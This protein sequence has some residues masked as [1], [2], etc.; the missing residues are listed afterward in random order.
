MLH[1]AV[2]VGLAAPQQSLAGMMGDGMTGRPERL[3]LQG[4]RAA[5]PVVLSGKPRQQAPTTRHTPSG[6]APQR[7][8]RTC[9]RAR[10]PLRR[11]GTGQCTTLAVHGQSAHALAQQR[12]S[13]NTSC[14]V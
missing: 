6:R 11:A 10:E 12:G 3:Q 1:G 13:M 8:W 9:G 2:L 5:A 7:A 4:Q 14:K